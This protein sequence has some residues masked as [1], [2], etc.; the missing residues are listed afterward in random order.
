MSVKQK[1]SDFILLLKTEKRYQLLAIFIVGVA[2]FLWVKGPGTPR[3]PT[4]S[5][6]SQD[7]ER[8][9]ELEKT[10]SLANKEAYKDIVGA[11][12]SQIEA[13][14]KKYA[15]QVKK[16][17]E[18]DKKIEEYNERTAEIFKRI[19]NNM[20]D[21]QASQGN[22][23]GAG[24][25]DGIGGPVDMGMAD[26]MTETGMVPQEENSLESFGDMTPQEAPPPPPAEPNK[27][28]F[29]GAGDSVTVKLIAGVR[30]PTDGTPY[31]VL[32]KLIG[33]VYGPDGS[34]LPLGEARLIAAAQGS[35]TDS[36]VLFRLTK[37]NIRL[38]NGRRKVL[39]VDGW[40]VG[41]D[42]LRGMQGIPI[43]PIGKAIAA[44]GMIGGLAALGDGLAKSTTT[45]TSDTFGGTEEIITGDLGKFAV[46]KGTSGFAREWGRIVAERVKQLVPHVEVYSGREGTAIFA[47][48]VA[49]KGL[50]EAM[51]NEDDVFS[52]MD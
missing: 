15:E 32:F 6:L 35:L 24:S 11:L 46:G 47:E 22:I 27:V 33:D 23:V 42:G 34:A 28:A 7:R 40:V 4:R 21:M 19:L 2:L 26:G 9:A 25:P 10:R 29:V 13:S 8:Q 14:E 45:V 39:D 20:A 41:E 50:Y 49:V 37:L 5:Q 43:D 12:S 31:P 44:G 30:A 51:D 48:S 38:P 3:P 18:L 16:S 52:S 36:R 1:F 17:E